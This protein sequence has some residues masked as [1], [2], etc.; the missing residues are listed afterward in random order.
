[1]NKKRVVVS[2]ANLSPEILELLKKKFPTGYQ[3][4][5]IKVEKPNGDFFYAV[6]LDTD[7]TSYL[8]KVNVKIDAKPKEDDD[9]KDFFGDNDDI[10]TNEDNFPEEASE[11]PEE[12]YDD[13]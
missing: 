12:D 11:E 6:T 13:D 2:Y 7:D 8:I 5:V 10:G 1:M 3:N 9:E 4:H